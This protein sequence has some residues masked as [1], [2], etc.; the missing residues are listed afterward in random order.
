MV[1]AVAVVEVA[2]DTVL[3]DVIADVLIAP[4]AVVIAAAMVSKIFATMT[5]VVVFVMDYAVS[6]ELATAVAAVL[7]GQWPL[8]QGPCFFGCSASGYLNDIRKGESKRG[9]KIKLFM[10]SFQL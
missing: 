8:W 7:G 10:P 1:I 5:T 6:N 4:V 3:N 9:D 2:L